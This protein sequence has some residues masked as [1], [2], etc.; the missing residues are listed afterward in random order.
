MLWR[1]CDSRRPSSRAAQQ[2]PQRRSSRTDAAYATS[3]ICTAGRAP[4]L[5]RGAGLVRRS[6]RN[7]LVAKPSTECLQPSCK[8][9]GRGEARRDLELT[10]ALDGSSGRHRRS[11]V[12]ALPLKRPRVAATLRCCNRREGAVSR[13]GQWP[14][15]GQSCFVLAASTSTAKSPD[16][17]SARVGRANPGRPL[18]PSQGCGTVIRY[19]HGYSIHCQ[20]RGYHAGSAEEPRVVHRCAGPPARGESGQRLLPQRT[21]RRQQAFSGCGR[22][23]RPPR[24]ASAHRT[25]QRTAPSHR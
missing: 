12:A 20:H 1:R 9:L 21:D 4:C 2:E 5:R 25:G 17:Q 18:L 15:S 13:P 16:P 24:R 22:C 11:R 23:R 6:C 7:P 19:G 10:L 3:R 14:R 8:H